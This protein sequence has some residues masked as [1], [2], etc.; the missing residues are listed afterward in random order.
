MLHYSQTPDLTLF[1]AVYQSTLLNLSE[2]S[3]PMALPPP[4]P[5]QE[6]KCWPKYIESHLYYH[7][8]QPG[9]LQVTHHVALFSLV[10]ALGLCQP[11]KHPSSRASLEH[12]CVPADLVES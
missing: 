5:S 12:I 7:Y 9:L 1:T 8:Q 2:P 6:H 4:R 10:R 11:A 3:Q